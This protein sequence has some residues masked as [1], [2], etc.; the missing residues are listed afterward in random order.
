MGSKSAEHRSTTDQFFD[1]PRVRH[2]A[3]RI[4]ACRRSQGLGARSI[5][6]RRVPEGP[7]I[8]VT[9]SSGFS[10]T[11]SK[12]LQGIGPVT[13]ADLDRAGLLGVVREAEVL[14]VRL[15]HQVDR[16][17][18]DA[19]SRL[20][21]IVS[22]TTGLDHID[23]REVERR[24]IRLLSLRGETE[25]LREVRATAELTIGLMLA[26]LRQI[27][28]ATSHVLDGG[29]NR[30][31]FRGRELYG[32]TVGII[33]YGRLGRIVARYLM[34]FGAEVLMCDPHAR[35][36]AGESWP[37]ALPLQELLRVSDIVTLHASADKGNEGLLGG[38]EFSA[39]KR[40]AFLVNTARGQLIDESAL[41]ASLEC[42]HLA[43]AALDVISDERIELERGRPVVEY[44][45]DHG[46]LM[47]TPH[48]GGCTVESMEK[49]ELFLARRLCGLFGKECF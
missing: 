23:L 22:P 25:F 49:T 17:V 46:N 11:A 45:R 19:A 2:L 40:G 1:A 16:E 7:R 15:R 39:M 20:Q 21:V 6:V 27:P 13:L 5:E 12:L 9:E 24:K 42:G 29:W 33:G 28:A 4:Q 35:R 31:A 41:L 10:A 44:A 30:D 32:K 34:A 18:L 37:R 14:W 43:G 47:I 48:V 8:V 26:L 38:A 36:H 3:E